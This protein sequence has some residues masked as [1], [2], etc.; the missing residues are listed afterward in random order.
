MT[1]ICIP[2]LETTAVRQQEAA[3]LEDVVANP[4]DDGVRLLGMRPPA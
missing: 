3:F 2:V 1:A 4:D